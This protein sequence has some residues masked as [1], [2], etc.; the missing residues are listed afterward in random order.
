MKKSTLGLFS[1]VAVLCSCHKTEL[2]QVEPEANKLTISKAHSV[3]ESQ[4]PQTKSTPDGE[5]TIIPASY[6][7]IWNDAVMGVNNLLESVE[8][9]IS[10]NR[11]MYATD[12][13]GARRN[14][15]QRIL[16]ADGINFPEASGYVMTIIPSSHD[17]DIR[18]FNHAQG[19]SGFD[20]VVLY[21]YLASDQFV[22][23]DRYE[24]G[25]SVDFV[26]VSSY[27]DYQIDTLQTLVDKVM[28]GVKIFASNNAQTKVQEGDTYYLEA[29]V[30]IGH[31]SCGGT[32][33]GYPGSSDNGNSNGHYFDAFLIQSKVCNPEGSGGGGL[34]LP[35]I[36]ITDDFKNINL[37]QAQVDKVKQTIATLETMCAAKW[38][39]NSLKGKKISIGVTTL[40]DGVGAQYEHGLGII[41]INAT[42]FDEKDAEKFMCTFIHEVYHAYQDRVYYKW[43][44]NGCANFIQT[45]G[46]INLEFEAYT[47]TNLMFCYQQGQSML[48]NIQPPSDAAEWV[49]YYVQSLNDMTGK[50]TKQITGAQIDELYKMYHTNFGQSYNLTD[51]STPKLDALKSAVSNAINNE[52]DC[53]NLK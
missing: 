32:S 50:F 6:T 24:R 7:P 46:A 20:G 4:K 51:F 27:T 31:R 13:T 23:V 22:R 48:R 34:E 1:M 11:Q 49:E 2:P 36:T 53:Y 9:P 12:A 43:I 18:A 19:K 37:N 17:Y 30:I 33:F 29:A 15:F 45:N 52:G 25:V 3:F 39:L 5:L 42:T 41:T 21:H 8:A 14:V 47:F 10:S 40:S 38:L 26:W 28:G 16:V 44:K 35:V